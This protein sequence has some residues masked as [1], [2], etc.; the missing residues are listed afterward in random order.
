MD[1]S[2]KKFIKLSKIFPKNCLS[3]SFVLSINHNKRSILEVGKLR[4]AGLKKI[5]LLSLRFQS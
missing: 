4:P 1:K 5:T 3:E 2:F